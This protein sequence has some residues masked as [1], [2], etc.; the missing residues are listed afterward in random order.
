MV[1][2]FFLFLPFLH[3]QVLSSV[4]RVNPQVL[5]YMDRLLDTTARQLVSAGL[6][7]STS[8]SYNQVWH[9]F[10]ALR[11]STAPPTLPEVLRYIASLHLRRIQGTT[12]ASKISA[13]SHFCRLQGWPDHTSTRAVRLAV[14]GA[15]RVIPAQP[16][17]RAALSWIQLMQL[18]T[19]LPRVCSSPHEVRLFKTCFTLAFL[20]CFR[21]GE[22]VAKSRCHQS[23]LLLRHITITTRRLVITLPSSKASQHIP[24]R[25]VIPFR[26]EGTTLPALVCS[27]HFLPVRHTPRTA[28]FSHRDGSPLTYYQVTYVLRKAAQECRFNSTPS[29]HC[30]RIS[31]ATFYAQKGA[32]ERELQLRGRWRSSAYKRYLRQP[33]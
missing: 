33:V 23:P 11:R 32:S 18:C 26:D 3:P 30:F 15:T 8:R 1:A 9:D 25:I 7:A 5:S 6:S 13:V 24:Q 31:G 28:F 14:R 16:D 22:L 21:M 20:G 12:I 29:P 17:R 4:D 27:P 19:A 10:N 2:M